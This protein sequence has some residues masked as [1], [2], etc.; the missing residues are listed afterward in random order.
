[1]NGAAYDTYSSF[2]F[3]GVYTVVPRELHTLECNNECAKAKV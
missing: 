3:G 2:K 1:M